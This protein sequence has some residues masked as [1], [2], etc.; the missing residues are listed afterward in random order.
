MPISSDRF[1]QT[2]TIPRL[3]KKYHSLSAIAL[4]PPPPSRSPLVLDLVLVLAFFSP[5]RSH[6]YQHQRSLLP[7]K[8]KPSTRTS[9]S[10][11]FLFL[12]VPC[13]AWTKQKAPGSFRA[14]IVQVFCERS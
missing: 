4:D 3:S 14:P 12:P 10:V 11:R 5:F 2:R 8:R 6:P 1:A 9:S 13:N 7:V